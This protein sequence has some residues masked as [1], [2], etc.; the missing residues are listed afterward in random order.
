MSNYRNHNREFASNQDHE[1]IAQNYL[2][3]YWDSIGVQVERSGACKNYDAIYTFGGIANTVE[4]KYRFTGKL[5]S[6]IL[7]EIAQAV[8]AKYWGWFVETPADIL[9]YIF[10]TTE[11]VPFQAFSFRFP[12]LRT[13]YYETYLAEHP[14]GSYVCST[15]GF[16]VTI[17]LALPIREIPDHLYKTHIIEADAMGQA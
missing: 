2:D 14:H 17:N 1:S 5:Y 7:V 6:D 12:E 9:N 10:C 4:E 3:K 16:G 15:K 8:D 13:W 11:F